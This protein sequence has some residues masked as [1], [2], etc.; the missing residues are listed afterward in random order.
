M[1]AIIVSLLV[2]ALPPVALAQ[3]DELP[4]VPPKSA[5]P[6]TQPPGSQPP[7]GS[8]RSVTVQPEPWFRA[9]ARRVMRRN[10][11]SANAIFM[12]SCAV[13]AVM[14]TGR[15]TRDQKLMI[16]RS[17]TFRPAGAPPAVGKVT[18]LIFRACTSRLKGVAAAR[19]TQAANRTNYRGGW[20]HNLCLKRLPPR[21]DR[22]K[23]A[24]FC[25]CWMRNI[26][27]SPDISARG[28]RAI[29][30]TSPD[31][32]GRAAPRSDT[33]HIKSTGLACRNLLR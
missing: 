8:T 33:A 16:L 21:Y 27:A 6:G 25:D 10:V 1:R 32:D 2:C 18:G 7:G 19:R 30:T 17:P 13:G 29:L 4:I 5:P 31:R 9:C 20:F 14:A 11:K 26:R 28:K 12:C 3:S 22:E 15:L 24:R 23:G